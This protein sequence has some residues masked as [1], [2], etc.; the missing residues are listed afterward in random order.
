M[1]LIRNNEVT[2][3]DIDLTEQAFDPDVGAI[4]GKTMRQR[5]NPIDNNR[6][7]IPE[8]LISLHEEITI[9]IDGLK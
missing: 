7:E 5:P 2:T 6:I 9:S 1:N 3:K 4:K 8:E